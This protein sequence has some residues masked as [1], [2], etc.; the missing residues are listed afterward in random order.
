MTCLWMTIQWQVLNPGK[1]RPKIQILLQTEGN[2][3]YFSHY[4]KKAQLCRLHTRMRCSPPLLKL[5]LL[6]PLPARFIT[7]VNKW[8]HLE[9]GE[10]FSFTVSVTQRSIQRENMKPPHLWLSV[11][12]KDKARKTNK[13]PKHTLKTT[14]TKTTVNR[15][16]NVLRESWGTLRIKSHWFFHWGYTGL[17]VWVI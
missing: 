2:Q 6:V 13:K 17:H 7:P 10:G 12:Q 14:T 1:R 15:L 9:E 5:W 3:P 16:E 4:P 8:C 11:V